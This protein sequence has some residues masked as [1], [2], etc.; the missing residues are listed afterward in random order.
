[1]P[2]QVRYQ[3]K[4]EKKKFTK[5]LSVNKAVKYTTAMPMI[6]EVKASPTSLLHRQ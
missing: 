3:A 4:P 1:L 6:D 2:N 5:D